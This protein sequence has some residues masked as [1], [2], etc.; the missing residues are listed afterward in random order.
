M[1]IRRKPQFLSAALGPNLFMEL[2]EELYLI[3]EG[4]SVMFTCLPDVGLEAY[5][6]GLSADDTVFFVRGLA[7]DIVRLETP[8]GERLERRW[9]DCVAALMRGYNCTAP[10]AKRA[11]G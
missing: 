8:G 7:N 6:Y 3:S 5:R 11:N 4:A 1:E 2:S 9:E 10:N